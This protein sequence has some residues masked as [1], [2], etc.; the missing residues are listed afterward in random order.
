MKLGTALLA[1]ILS[2]SVSVPSLADK[3]PANLNDN[4][5]TCGQN[6]RCFNKVMFGRTYKVIQTVQFTVMVSISN[7]GP[8]TR[9]DVSITN[10]G[11]YPQNV[12]PQDFRV[13][14]LA[15]KPRVLLYVPPSEL[16]NLPAPQ[17]VATPKPAPEPPQAAPASPESKPV[18]TDAEPH[19]TVN[20]DE[21]F[22][23]AKREEARKEAEERAAAERHLAAAT[24]PANELVR[25]RVYF[26]KDPKAKQVNIVLP[27]SGVVFEFPYSMNF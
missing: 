1:V 10:N 4:I 5:L 24:I 23:Q 9:A 13:E 3:I 17:P 20:I 21:L 15:P 25:G 6:T 2:G 16:Q 19:K 11:D 18:V 27:I 7:E 26:E 14:V 8:Y 12:S 22:A